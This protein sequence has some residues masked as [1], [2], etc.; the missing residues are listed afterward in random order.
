MGDL[1]RNFDSSEFR[2]GHCGRLVGPDA[3]LVTVLQRLR[4]ELGKPLRIVS[5]YRC[6]QHNRAVGG[7]VFSQHLHGRAADIPR[8]LVTVNMARRAGAVGIGLRAGW[9]IHVDMTPGRKTFTFV[10]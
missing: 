6:R 9:V 8:G 1:S 3:G 4:D 10:E 2:C 5:G 7:A